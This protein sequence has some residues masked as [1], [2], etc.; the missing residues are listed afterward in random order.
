MFREDQLED[1][2]CM[3]AGGG[4]V[5]QQAPAPAPSPKAEGRKKGKGAGKVQAG[6]E[7]K[8]EKCK[9]TTCF[10][11]KPSCD[12][13]KDSCQCKA[14]KTDVPILFKL[15]EKQETGGEDKLKEMKKSKPKEFAVIVIA[16][17]KVGSGRLG[18]LN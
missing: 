9:C 3:F 16:L 1:E 7:K 17:Q 10:V 11:L 14:C 12:F 4:A 6:E 2:G 8:D 15:A 18:K 13:G 5:T